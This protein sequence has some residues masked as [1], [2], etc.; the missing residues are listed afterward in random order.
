MTKSKVWFITGASKGLGLT[1]VKQLLNNGEKVA[2]T[3]RTIAELQKAV[4]P[5]SEHF[6]PLS[7]NLKDE[8]SVE[9]AIKSTVQKFGSIDVI[10]NNAGYGLGGSIEELTDEE[11]RQNFDIN[12]FGTLNVIRK[13]L[14][15]LRA[16]K[17]GTSSILLRPEV[18]LAAAALASTAEPNLP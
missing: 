6:L 13:A 15:Y 3:S 16:E 9:A 11:T 2:A 18:I 8:A 14:P 1:L 5:E 7:V 4:Q 12:V 17:S 10:V